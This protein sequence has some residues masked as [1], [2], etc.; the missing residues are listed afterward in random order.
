MS[1]MDDLRWV[2][3][4]NS[5]TIPHYLIEQIKKRDYTVENFM[6]YMDSICPNKTPGGSP[7]NPYQ[8]LYAMATPDNLTKGVLWF[9][10]DPLTN[11]IFIQTYSV[12]KEYW[13]EGGAVEKCVKW[14]KEI[15]KKANL[16]KV[17]WIT[18]Y[19]KHSK[20]HGFKRS[21]GILMEYNEPLEN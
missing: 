10:I 20:K 3:A 6:K 18:D 2:R 16:K 12:D 19:E 8:H 14:I 17:Y 1:K 21:R 15:R 4:W 7:F 13:K 5:S 11:D 9:S